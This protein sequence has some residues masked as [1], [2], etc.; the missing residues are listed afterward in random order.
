MDRLTPEQK[1]VYDKVLKLIGASMD[2]YMNRTIGRETA[3]IISDNINGL[4][5]KQAGE[6]GLKVPGDLKFAFKAGSD[7]QTMIPADRYTAFAMFCAMNAIPVTFGRDTCPEML[8]F[9]DGGTVG[10]KEGEDHLLLQVPKALDYIELN[11]KIDDQ[12]DVR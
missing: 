9:G 11:F 8:T 2:K 5:A 6:L 4:L 3:A 1:I 10:W 7:R 12:G